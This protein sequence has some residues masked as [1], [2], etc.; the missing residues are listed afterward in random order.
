MLDKEHAH[1]EFVR[2]QILVL[3][4]ILAVALPP[5]GGF[6]DKMGMR[7]LAKRIADLPIPEDIAPECING[8][9]AMLNEFLA[10]FDDVHDL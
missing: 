3:A 4:H 10:I 9:K 6:S 8:H 2:G 5:P 1:P 7:E